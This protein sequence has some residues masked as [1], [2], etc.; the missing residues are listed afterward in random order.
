MRRT[1]VADSPVWAAIERVDQR[2]ASGG[3]RSKVAT[4][5]RSMSASLTVRGAPGRGSSSRPSSPAWIKRARHLPTVW[6]VTPT[7]S[8]TARLLMPCPDSRIIRARRA[9]PF[10]LVVRRL[11][12]TSV[13]RCSSLITSGALGRPIVIVQSLPRRLPGGRPDAV[14]GARLLQY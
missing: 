6:G 1:V 4:I 9:G 3:V 12:P 2:V 13:W 5:T 7:R 14:Q 11:Q 10:A 8:A